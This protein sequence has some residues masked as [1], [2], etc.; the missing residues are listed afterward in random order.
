M[1][2]MK[3]ALLITGYIALLGVLGAY[4]YFAT[5]LVR[6][7]KQSRC[8]EVVIVVRDSL[9][10]PLIRAGEIASFL[11]RNPV[12]L[13]GKDFSHIDMYQL[14]KEV[15]SF[16]SVRQCNAVRTIDGTLRLEI[17]Q[18]TPL[19]RLE[20]RQGSFFVS[21][22]R[23]IFPIVNPFRMPVLI[24][25]GNIPFDYPPKYRGTMDSADTWLKEMSRMTAYI[26][27]HPFWSNKVESILVENTEDIIIL[28]RDEDLVLK[29]GNIGR[30]TSKMDKLREFY[31]VL[32]PLGGKE[33][34]N[35]VDARFGD[36]LVC[37]HRKNE[38]NI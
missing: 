35:L 6:E 16:A 31:R 17:L 27:A 4:F 13:L 15:E 8:Q 22:E 10:N 32:E 7:K 2:K 20:T 38:K 34:Y 12:E 24:V 18:H 9:L 5:I 3:K 19:F 21:P 1:R 28:P 14:E 33:K 36:Q 37:T 23:F 11:K 30:F 29:I 25:S 26:T